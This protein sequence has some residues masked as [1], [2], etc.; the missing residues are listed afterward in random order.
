MLTNKKLHLVALV[1]AALILF[2]IFVSSAASAATEQSASSVRTYA[3]ISNSES[4]NV[5][6]IDTTTDTVIATVP[7]GKDP[8]GVAVSPDGRRVYV[9]NY[10]DNTVSVIDTATNTVKA[11]LNVGRSPNGVAVNPQGTK[12]YVTNTW[13]GNI[14]VID[15]ATNTVTAAVMVGSMPSGVA[16]NPQGTRVYVANCN[17]NTVSIIDTATNT[18]IATVPVENWP[19]GVAVNPTGTKIYVTNSGYEDLP[20]NTISVI[21]AATNTV[22]ASVEVGNYP[23]GVAVNPDGT[24]VYVVNK[25]DST[26]SV[27]DAVTNTVTSTVNVGYYNLP[28]GVA[29]N[30]EGTKVY[31]ANWGRNAVSV[32][33]T[34]TNKITATVKVGRDPMTFGQFIGY[35]PVPELIFPVA[36]FSSNVTSG[37]APLTVQFTDLSENAT[38]WGWDFGDGDTSTDENPVHTFSEA[39]EYTVELTVSNEN[40]TDSKLATISVS[41]Q[42]ESLLPVANFSSNVTSG[43]APLTVQFTDLSE[44]TTGWSW[45][46]GD[47]DTSTDENPVH[48]FSEKGEYTV[49]LTVSNENGT[50][51]KVASISVS[52]QPESLLPVA[53]FS[54]NVTSGSSPLTVQF[55]DLSENATGW[56][57][58]FGDGNTSTDKNPIHTYYTAGEYTVDL[59]V[60]N[61]NGTDSKSA[62]ISVD[63]RSYYSGNGHYYNAVSVPDGITW[64]D[65]KKAAE[66][67]TYLGMSGHLATI[68]SQGE[69]DF[70]YNNLGIT[71]SDYWLGAFQ[72]DGSQEPDGGWKWVTGELWDYTN[73]ESGEPND[74]GSEDALQFD[75]FTSTDK[76]NDYSH[77]ATVSGYVVEYEPT[78][79][80]SII[81]VANFTSNVTNGFAPLTVKFTDLSKNATSW[82]WNF[83]DGTN[84]T[85]QNPIHTL[86]EKG[87]YTVNLT[88]SNENGTDSKSATISVDSLLP[89]AKFV[90]N[91]TSGSSPLSVQ[92][93]DQSESA[94]GWNWNFGDGTN[95]TEQNPMH[96]FSVAGNYTVN[97][98]VSN[99]NG[100]DSKVATINVSENYGG[101]T[102]SVDVPANPL[103][104]DTGIKIMKGQT[105]SISAS[106]T[107]N[108]GLG[109]SGPDGDDNSAYFW[110]LFLTSDAPSKLGELIAFVGPQSTDPYQGHWGDSSFF[111][112]PAGAGYW[113]IGSSA[114]FTADR[115][116]DLWLGI[117]DDAVSENIYDNSG[118]LTTTVTITTPVDSLPLANFTSNLTSGFALLTVQF[119]DLSKNATSWNWNFG[120]GTN[121]TEQNPVHTFSVVGNYTVNLTVS[122]AYGTDSKLTTISVVPLPYYSVNGHYYNAVSVP[123]GITWTDAK[124]AAESSTYLGMSGHLATITSQGEN[125]FIYNNLGMTLS[126]YL[127]GAYQP[128]GSQE[129]DGGWQWVT[130]EPWNYTNWNSGEPNDNGGSE[131]ALQFDYSDTW[132]DCPH[133]YTVGGYVVEYE[134][135]NS[136]SVLPVANFSSNVTYGYAPLTVKFI[137]LS[138]NATE[139]NW[140]F[141]DG[142]NSTEQDPVHTFS[143]VGNYTVNLTA[144]NANGTDSKSATITVSEKPVSI[145]PVANF[146]TNVSEGYA[147][148]SI[149]FTDLSENAIGWNWN[150][151]DEA[152]SSEQ[153]PVHIFSVAGNYTVNLTVSNTNG[154]DSKTATIT[155]TNPITPLQSVSDIQSSN[156]STWINWTWKNPI[157]TNFNH[158]EIY[159]NGTF[160]S[161]TS[162]ENFNATDLQ[163]ETIYT[164]STRTADNNGNVN[165]TWVNSTARTGA[166]NVAG[167][168]N[169]SISTDKSIYDRGETVHI[170]GKAQHTDGSPIVNS[171][172]LLN[173]ILKGYTQTYSLVTD[174]NGN[175]SYD[176]KPGKTEAGNFTAKLSMNSNGHL[177]SAETFFN[178][179][180]LY[181]T[182]SGTVDYEMSKNSSENITFSL[183]NYG[184][185]DLHGVNVTLDGETIPGVETQVLDT[186][187]ETLSA[188][189]QG[190]FIVKISSEN[191]DVSQ[192]NYTVRVTSDEGSSEEAKLFVHLVDAK[193]AAIVSPTSIE[194]GMN[195][196]NNLVKT[197]DISNAGYES[198][199]DITISKPSLDWVSVS[200]ASLGNI[201][202]GM[203]KSFN[204]FLNP[205]NNTAVG[206]Y[207]ETIS[208]S[209]SNHQP[210]NIYLRISVTSS[211]KGD[212]IFHVVDELGENISGASIEIQNPAV[213]TDIFTGTTD[214]NGYYNF[215]NIS[216]GTYNYFVRASDQAVSG[217]ST[218][219]PGIQNLV[220]PVLP[221]DML[222]VKLNVTLVKIDDDYVITPNFTFETDV[223][224][225]LLIPDP[226][227]I[228]YGVDRLNPVYEKDGNITISNSG[229][230]SVFNV[231][232]DSS[233]LQGVNITFP[234][235]NTFFVDEIKAKSSITIPYHLKVTNIA[236]GGDEYRNS[237]KINGDYIYFEPNSDVTHNVYLSSEIPTFV[238]MY[239]CS[240]DPSP[241]D[242]SS[243]DTPN[244]GDTPS[245]VDI[246]SLIEDYFTYTYNAP[247]ASYSPIPSNVESIPQVETVHERV[248]FNIPQNATLERDAFSA[249]LELTNKLTDKNIENV[250]VNLKIKDK[251]GNDASSLFFVNQPSLSNINSINGSGIISPSSVANANWLLVPKKNAGGTSPSGKGYTVQAFIDYTVNG[252]SFSTNSTEESITVMPQPLL[253]LVYTIPGNVTADKPFNLTLNVT[254]VGYGTANNLKLD[255]GQPKIYENKAGLLISFE[256]IG[257]GLV[258]GHDSNSMLINFGD[259]A[260]GESKEA[261]WVMKTSLDG[262]F[263]EF[264]GSFSHD[265]T[266]G[267][268]ETSL[269]NDI[270]YVI[271]KIPVA[272]F[273][274][275]ITQGYVPLSVQFTDLSKNAIGWEWNFGDGN[276]STD[277]N[278]THTY[279]TAGNY[280]VNLTVS[281]VYGTDSK[282]ATIN[283]SEKPASILP[284]ANFSTNVS[285]G[286]A[287]LSVQFT[288][289]S[290]NATSW[291]WDFGDGT[292]ATEQNV[293]HTY[294]SVGKYTVNLTVSNADGSDSEVKTD[295]I[296]VNEPLPGAPVANFTATPT[297]GTAPLTVNFTDQSTGNVSS[298]SWDFDNDGNV[299]STEQNPVYT[300]TASGNYTVNLT[301]ANANGSD[302]KVK[303]K[304][305]VVN[306]P[307]PGA[308]IANFTANV[309]SGTTPLD[310]QFTDASTGNVSSYSWDFDND[311]TVDSTEQNPVYTYAAAGNYTVNLTVSNAGGSDSK[312]KTGYIEVLSPSTSK[313]VAAFSASPTSGKVPLNVAFTDTST[314]IPA[315]WI[316]DFGDGSKS[317]LQNPIHKYSKTGIYKVS[318]TVK[319]V[320]GS[321]TATKTDYIKV[322]VK[323]VANFTSS[324]T[325]GKVP[326]NVAFTDTSTGSPTSWKWD[327]GDGSKSY[328]QNPTHKYSKAGTYTVNLTVKNAIGR[329]TVTKTEYIKVTGV[330]KPVANFTSSVTSGKVPLNIAFTDTSTGSPTSW[331]WDFGDGSKSY[332]QNPTHKYSKAGIY[333]VNLTV[334]NAKGSN[335]VTKTEYIK[336]VTKPVADFSATPT[337]GKAPLTVEF[338][339][340]S[341][342][343]PTAWKWSFGDGTTSTEQN[344]EHQYLQ[345]GKYKVTL[346]VVNVAGSNTTTK[347]NYIKVTT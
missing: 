250:S 284:V 330:T 294:T 277:P 91:V 62:T 115:D 196:G 54:S 118:F 22:T 289:L 167:D 48:T 321:N 265:N 173:I 57:W 205:G 182:P 160:Q 227:A 268:A 111:P 136:T 143:A 309:T 114:T 274:A 337:S 106:G 78:N 263:T 225:P 203:N 64:T 317:F 220:K 16:V 73:W 296:I 142:D 305:I 211:E 81:P 95:S 280:T 191:V 70:V 53:N 7:V 105:V 97:L 112:Q 293:S 307:L 84:S 327:F 79:N 37:S 186:P 169:V 52:E 235:G 344:P 198:M 26:V 156:G 145:F 61:E 13:S 231:T 267:G 19:S 110:E 14:S 319:N 141:G 302:F 55:T 3:Y 301:V 184:E 216:A 134:P 2:L 86:S 32:I 44:N 273:T 102:V 275:D 281:N 255:S 290:E 190:S 151:G 283:V 282:S 185:I 47:G 249:S 228:I 276:T 214:E 278:P 202:P 247:T 155:V 5:S 27:I 183:R 36:N 176:F 303:T 241:V 130:G 42:P 178:M 59:T 113:A 172:A 159:L 35:V 137:D 132:N 104:T 234:T 346:K 133:Y 242:P 345:G 123:E 15:T 197:I 222:G 168:F 56:N 252:V 89:L 244:P 49:N 295:Y 221:K 117:N 210:V 68:T 8:L 287:P 279:Y 311:G 119:T 204:I 232:V 135:T 269:I 161:N 320:K 74:A 256:L 157:D 248:K 347:T 25:M 103:W 101:S 124:T 324:V 66:S 28:Y 33:D 43:S 149:Q 343:V 153:D 261:Y 226:V 334:K 96:T 331:K 298:Y 224:Q 120:D 34:A 82:N 107:W 1:S 138:E 192:A 323:P 108:T 85:E 271:L 87:E 6:V 158:T 199:K 195:P 24:K 45:D 251:D 259:L 239:N 147:P 253:N 254:N 83:G 50:D 58:N 51:S 207:Q 236:C 98:T 39:G 181:M 163:P 170:T 41:E 304:Y 88:V 229:L 306:E 46:F 164:L 332:L 60:S 315:K 38:G 328:L 299:D 146:S 77:E 125:D 100:T 166:E 314:G 150:F 131:D 318:L 148:L 17:S 129:P 75:G 11:T 127:L 165:K 188:G 215:E 308:P 208:I 92:F 162:A 322:I 230:I 316:W 218:V 341:T 300:Y 140:D 291:L 174:S 206:V 292:N 12:V 219:S 212:L 67:S 297:S 201:S 336:V 90:S 31:V 285:E 238:Y 30:P 329:N 122:N 171:P 193:P 240:V 40:G 175:I 223:P 21:D 340:N 63:S 4:N 69:N 246:P 194:V 177:M 312:V 335:T 262:N 233:S 342:G 180:G 116:G 10:L 139:W 264:D 187:S 152:T 245:S 213:L 121:S 65:A 313:L 144:N 325:S 189:A 29:V 93:T 179:Y 286:Y 9:A 126:D 109:E 270:K 200:S 80:T 333:T 76:W 243:G 72:P 260:P 288:D 71:P 94:T 266:L 310:V 209:S 272:N 99:E 23:Y 338:T 258:N 18:V 339:D 257:S 217:S 154:T 128:E 20:E 237:I 326:L